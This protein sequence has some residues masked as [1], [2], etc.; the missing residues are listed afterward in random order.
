M[1]VVTKTYCDCCG[2]EITGESY[3]DK[4]YVRRVIRGAGDSYSLHSLD[5]CDTCQAAIDAAIDAIF[6]PVVEEEINNET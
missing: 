3:V 4:Y 5:L 6:N 1:A 2:Q